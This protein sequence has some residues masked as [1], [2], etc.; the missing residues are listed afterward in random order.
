MRCPSN[1]GGNR[2]ARP[3]RLADKRDV[4]GV[5]SPIRL[6]EVVL[7]GF[8]LGQFIAGNVRDVDENIVAVGVGAN[9]SLDRAR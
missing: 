3:P 9:A 8:V 6:F 1:G 7:H 4:Y 5:Q 2:V